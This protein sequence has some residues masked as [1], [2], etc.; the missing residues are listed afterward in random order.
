MVSLHRLEGLG[1][2]DIGAMVHGW[3]SGGRERGKKKN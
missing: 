1:F 3:E 2:R